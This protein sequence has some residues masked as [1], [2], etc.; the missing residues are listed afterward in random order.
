MNTT[1]P[2]IRVL[3][4]PRDSS[5]NVIHQY[6]RGKQDGWLLFT[7]HLYMFFVS[8]GTIEALIRKGLVTQLRSYLY[9]TDRG[10]SILE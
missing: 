7:E 8:G 3:R 4:A 5:R 10:R 6:R 2:Q 1:T 9:I